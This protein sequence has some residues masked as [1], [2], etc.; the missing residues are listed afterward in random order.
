M[1]ERISDGRTGRRDWASVPTMTNLDRT[2][3][4]VPNHPNI[5]NW[6]LVGR[7]RRA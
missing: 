7:E 4:V 3:L 2:T 5:A 6:E 1:L